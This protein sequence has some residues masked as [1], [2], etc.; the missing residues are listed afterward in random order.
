LPSALQAARAGPLLAAQVVEEGVLDDRIPGLDEQLATIE[1]AI[2]DPEPDRTPEQAS[3]DPVWITLRGVRP[4]Q[5]TFLRERVPPIGQLESAMV[6]EAPAG[7]SITAYETLPDVKNRLEIERA[8]HNEYPS[9]LMEAGVGG[10]VHINFLI[11]EEG[12]VVEAF[13]EKSSGSPQLDRAA[14]RVARKFLFT[15][16]VNAAEPVAVWI[17]VPITFQAS[18][19]P[20]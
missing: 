7:Q 3:S 12:A 4:P 20:A 15:P 11:D 18:A 16:A 14:W 1:I 6:A 19:A 5:P 17:Q 2:P 9:Y 13:M 10:T 8:L